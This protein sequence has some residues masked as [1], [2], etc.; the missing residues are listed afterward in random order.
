MRFSWSVILKINDNLFKSCVLN[1][2]FRL[3]KVTNIYIH[4]KQP[5][6]GRKCLGSLYLV[7]I[8]T[9]TSPNNMST[10]ASGNNRY[11]GLNIGKA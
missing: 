9:S 8:F 4:K 2:T 1:L 7:Q 6:L 11:W 10:L 5:F 3:P